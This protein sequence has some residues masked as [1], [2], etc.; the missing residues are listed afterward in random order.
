MILYYC[1]LKFVL[2]HV[3][4]SQRQ[5]EISSTTPIWSLCINNQHIHISLM[6]RDV[7][8]AQGYIYTSPPDMFFSCIVSQFCK[9]S[10]HTVLE[11]LHCI[12]ARGSS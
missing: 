5:T 3:I 11:C 10:L 4:N 9:C 1:D 7:V 8:W 12:R 6:C 2:V